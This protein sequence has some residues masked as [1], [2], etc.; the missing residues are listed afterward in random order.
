MHIWAVCIQLPIPPVH[1][2]L[3]FWK[4]IPGQ[5]LS[6]LN[7]CELISVGPESV[8]SLKQIIAL[9]QENVVSLLLALS[10]H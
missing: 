10:P 6:L 5:T 9:E 4:P 3:H 7:T 1:S 8:S 2:H